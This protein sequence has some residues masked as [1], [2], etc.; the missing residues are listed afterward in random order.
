MSSIRK[1]LGLPELEENDSSRIRKNFN[2]QPLK[3]KSNE[4]IT[5][6]ERI[7]KSKNTIDEPEINSNLETLES[8]KKRKGAPSVSSKYKSN[9]CVCK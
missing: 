5:T 2:L 9:I 3:E 1:K 7:F 4:K 6:L 8:L